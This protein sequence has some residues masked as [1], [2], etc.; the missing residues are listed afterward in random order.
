MAAGFIA[1]H[2]VN[3]HRRDGLHDHHADDHQ[4][5]E[6]EGAPQ[7]RCASDG[8]FTAQKIPPLCGAERQSLW[9]MML[10]TPVEMLWLFDAIES[11]QCQ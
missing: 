3:S 10:L 5:P 4:I 7:S 1:D 6:G 8:G 9:R 2:S 11:F